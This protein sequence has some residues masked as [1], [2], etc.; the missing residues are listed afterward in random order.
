MNNNKKDTLITFCLFINFFVLCH[1]FYMFCC[2]C[3]SAERQTVQYC[4]IQRDMLVRMQLIKCI[5]NTFKM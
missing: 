4:I 1:I 2:I 5:E 3:L